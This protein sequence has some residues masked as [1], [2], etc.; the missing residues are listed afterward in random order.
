VA[1]FGDT[2]RIDDAYGDPRFNP[3]I[4]RKTGFRTK[5]ILCVPIRDQAGKVFAVTQLLNRQDGEPFDD[6]DE[7]KFS[8]FADSLGVILEA[9]HRLHEG[10]SAKGRNG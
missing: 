4:D 2:I 8:E 3:E 6:A 10:N 5:S 9:L 1:Q 7:H